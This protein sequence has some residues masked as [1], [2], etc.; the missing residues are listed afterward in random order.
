MDSIALVLS[1]RSSLLGGLG[2]PWTRRVAT[3]VAARGAP[4]AISLNH[5]AAI[6]SVVGESIHVRGGVTSTVLT[7]VIDDQGLDTL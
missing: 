6:N 1:R 3:R 7:D 2:Q 4:I 5:I